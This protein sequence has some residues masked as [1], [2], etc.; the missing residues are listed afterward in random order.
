LSFTDADDYILINMK[1]SEYY[2]Q[3]ICLK[4]KENVDKRKVFLS[5]EDKCIAENRINNVSSM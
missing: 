2:N 1:N 5:L 3:L 4:G